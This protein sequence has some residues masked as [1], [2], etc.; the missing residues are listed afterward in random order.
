MFHLPLGFNFNMLEWK[1][2]TK[3]LYIYTKFL[4][5]VLSFA[6]RWVVQIAKHFYPGED[7]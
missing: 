6:H 7:G 5:H 2:L 1:T 3:H 4:F